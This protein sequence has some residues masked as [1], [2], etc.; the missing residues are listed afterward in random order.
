MKSIDERWSDC[1]RAARSVPE[2]NPH[3]APPGYAA[4]I[5]R[6]FMPSASADRWEVWMLFARRGLAFAAVAT[7]AA[8][9]LAWWQLGASALAAPAIGDE[10]IEQVIWQP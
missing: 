2:P 5:V 6:N 9:M 8:V 10:A 1:V 7:I 3:S 4:R